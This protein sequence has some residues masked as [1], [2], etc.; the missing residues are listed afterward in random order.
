MDSALRGPPFL[1]SIV[2]ARALTGW[3]LPPKDSVNGRARYRDHFGGEDGAETDWK[4]ASRPLELSAHSARLCVS[5]S[6]ER[7]PPVD[8]SGPAVDYGEPTT[9]NLVVALLRPEPLLARASGAAVLLSDL[10]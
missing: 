1:T 6:P 2:R 5:I 8:L 9:T 3:T 4:G 10:P 7:A